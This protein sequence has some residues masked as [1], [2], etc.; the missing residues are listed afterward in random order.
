[1]ASM[2]LDVGRY[3][4]ILDRNWEWVLEKG[5][6]VFVVADSASFDYDGV[7]YGGKVT[8]NCV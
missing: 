8:L 6:Y 2:E 7:G 5:E 1:M 4:P 3:L